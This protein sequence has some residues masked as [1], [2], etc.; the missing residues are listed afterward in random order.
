MSDFTPNSKIMCEI[1]CMNPDSVKI[2]TRKLSPSGIKWIP[3]TC[4]ISGEKEN[5]LLI[6][7]D[8][9]SQLT[10]SLAEV[11]DANGT[12]ILA[13]LYSAE[14]CECDVA[15]LTNL[16][17]Q[18]VISQLERF[19]SLGVVTHRIIHGMNYFR[20]NSKNARQIFSGLISAAN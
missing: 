15:T 12:K 20:L 2:A 10:P 13:G 19:K 5:L 7:D 4:Q 11:E 18:E 3:Y 6:G 8:L 16:P 1:R 17:E 9:A 14:L